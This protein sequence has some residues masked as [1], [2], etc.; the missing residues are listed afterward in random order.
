VAMANQSSAPRVA[1]VGAS[2]AVGGAIVELIRE[3]GLSFSALSLFASSAD[4]P[5][6]VEEKDEEQ[7]IQRLEDFHTLAD[8]DLALLAVPAQVA[9]EIAAVRPGPTLID[10]SGACEDRPEN[11]MVAPGF[12]SRQRLLELKAR[13]AVLTTPHSIAFAAATIL[14]ALGIESG[15]VSAVG[16]LGASS[17]GRNCARQSINQSAAALNG[18][19]EVA[20]DETQLAFN[21]FLAPGR[22]ALTLMLARQVEALMGQAPQLAIQ[23]VQVPVPHGAALSLCIPRAQDAADWRERLRSTPGV[24]LEEDKPAAL[25]EV[26]NQDAIVV[27]VCEEKPAWL[28]WCAFDNARL[29]AL[30]ALW[31]AEN[32]IF[33]GTAGS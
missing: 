11:A 14:R 6:G 30:A 32:L 17:F 22:Q 23:L 18:Q 1:V 15:L 16:M 13:R 12:T 4:E 31:A 24:L 26:V 19:L 20:S 21:V 7:D 8:F 3:R 28:V 27:S 25:I 10:L 5:S 2:G 33:A 29:A 9:S